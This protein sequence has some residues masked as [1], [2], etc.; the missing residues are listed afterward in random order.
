MLLG[1]GYTGCGVKGPPLAPRQQPVTAVLDLAYTLADQTI[2]LTWR[3]PGPLSGRQATHA[4]F[5]LHRSRTAL[6]ESDCD[7]CPLVFEKVATI[8]Y[9]ST[10]SNRFS[11]DAP[12]EPGYRYVFKVRL[13]MDGAAG[14]DSNAVKVDPLPDM[15]SGTTETP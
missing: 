3:L 5:V 15:P 12:L 11:T 10:P 6:G 14:T 2:A 9:V 8:P 7:G 13:E 1:V 4:V